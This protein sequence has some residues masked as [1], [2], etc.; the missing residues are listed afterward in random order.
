MA[1]GHNFEKY[2]SKLLSGESKDGFSGIVP[3]LY[4]TR[5]FLL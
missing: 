1:L 4:K 5:A 3:G 2:R